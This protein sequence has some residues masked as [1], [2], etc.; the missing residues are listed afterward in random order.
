LSD[1]NATASSECGIILEASS[2]NTLSGNNVANNGAGIYLCYCSNNT[3]Y[4]NSIAN[5]EQ[6]ISLDPSSD[7]RIYHN[8]I[9]NNADQVYSF[10]SPWYFTSVWDDGYP[11]GGNYWSDYADVDFFS[12][13]YQNETGSDGIGDTPYTINENNRDNYP[14]MAPYILRDVAVTN[15]MS[16]KD[17]CTPYPTVGK[18]C[19]MRIDALVENQGDFTETLDVTF[20][21]TNTTGTYVIGMGGV[22]GLLPGDKGDMIAFWNTTGFARAYN[23]SAYASTVDGESDVA[24][25]T[26]TGGT[27]RVSCIGDI[28]GDYV[29]DS[30]DYQRVKNAIPSMPGGPKWNTNADIN[31]DQVV[32]SKDYQIVK[33]HIPSQL[34]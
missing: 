33:T 11:S 20:Y 10:Y 15:V 27:I 28:N 31:N 22:T 14:L 8:N 21:V 13:P 29:T 25:N 24:D 12:G 4:G 5:N 7:N 32:D 3:I 18:G 23:M 2:N 6:G 34:P 19:S 17:G 1:N 26:F 16:S 9:I 30:K